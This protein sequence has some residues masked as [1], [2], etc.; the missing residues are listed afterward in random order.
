M[1]TTRALTPRERATLAS[2]CEAF[3]PALTAEA[4]DDAVLFAASAARLGVP[5]AAEEAIAR[6]A[7]AQQT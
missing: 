6:L 5:Q 2:L 7:P 4:G 1:E 3:Q